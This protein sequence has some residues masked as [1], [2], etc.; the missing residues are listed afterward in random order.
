MQGAAPLKDTIGDGIPSEA[1]W[2]K[3]SR[4][5]VNPE[6]LEAGRERFDAREDFVFVFRVLSRNEV[7]GYAEATQRVRGLSYPYS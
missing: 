1:R 5:F 3:I 4:K 7:E 2:T 6:A